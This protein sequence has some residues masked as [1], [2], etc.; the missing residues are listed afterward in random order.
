LFIIQFYY[1]YINNEKKGAGG[2]QRPKGV[3]GGIR[4]SPPILEGGVKITKKSN[5]IF[6]LSI[7]PKLY[8]SVPVTTISSG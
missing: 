6:L 7:I 8:P 4:I 3:S 5:Y 2:F 1:K